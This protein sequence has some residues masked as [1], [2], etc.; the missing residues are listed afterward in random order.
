MGKGDDTHLVQDIFQTLHQHCMG[1]EHSHLVLFSPQLLSSVLHGEG[2]QSSCPGHL[3]ATVVSTAWRG[4][5]V[6]L[7]RTFVSYF[8]STAWRENT[9]ILSRTASA[10]VVSTAWRE[11]TVILSRTAS[12]TVI[13]T[14]WR[15]NTVILSRTASATAFWPSLHSS[16]KAKSA[17]FI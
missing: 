16:Q 11:N 3:S 14:A 7:S 13:S 4:N 15:G 17:H 2:T 5:T 10:T 12:A 6:I 8:V 1:R 9:V